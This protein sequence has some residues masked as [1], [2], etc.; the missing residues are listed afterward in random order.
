M[1][2]FKDFGDLTVEN[3]FK[4]QT[5]LEF[6]RPLGRKIEEL[7]TLYVDRD[8]D[9]SHVYK[10]DV[11][12]V[13]I[14]KTI[15]TILSERFKAS[16]SIE[17]PM[18]QILSTVMVL[19]PSHNV[20]TGDMEKTLKEMTDF[21][22]GVK[23]KAGEDIVRE[24]E[25]IA[26]IDKTIKDMK[27]LAAHMDMK[28]VLVDL[29]N[30]EIHNLPKSYKIRVKM[31]IA[32]LVKIKA[33]PMEIVAGILHEI[34]HTVTAFIRVGDTV[35]N[36]AI[37]LETIREEVSIRAKS[38]ITALKI[39]NKKLGGENL[40]N[41]EDVSKILVAVTS[42]LSGLSFEGTDNFTA[43]QTEK[44]RFADLFVTRFL[45]GSELANLLV[46][47]GPDYRPKTNIEETG[48]LQVFLVTTLMTT[49]A[50]LSLSFIPIII[51]L[52]SMV[53][54]LSLNFIVSSKEL[55]K[56][57]KKGNVYETLVKRLEIIKRENIKQLRLLNGDD[58]V[59][60]QSRDRLMDTIKNL[61]NLLKVTKDT[62]PVL[63]KL[64]DKVS[65]DKESKRLYMTKEV[66][67]KLMENDLQYLTKKL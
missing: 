38:P 28:E 43:T 13:N 58:I 39:A 65:V 14:L 2:I 15:E 54:G 57:F 19:P 31:N 3:S 59:S 8:L 55:N 66:F 56:Y 22:N 12:I 52:C 24:N 60:M 48:V 4:T 64:L 10:K 51:G 46:K 40:D 37:L 63:S 21:I 36:S 33:T 9:Q 32:N 16:I 30:G 7:Q 1:N 42:S 50:I 47:I 17:M 27:T 61:D 44:E 23:D 11:E 25:F 6:I 5:N 41:E 45:L 53:L 49:V 29:V 20:L 18:D 35:I 34:G 26:D 62:R 67:E